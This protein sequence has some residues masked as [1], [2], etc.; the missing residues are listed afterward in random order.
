MLDLLC[1]IRHETLRISVISRL[2]GY[3]NIYSD[4]SVADPPPLQESEGVLDPDEDIEEEVGLFEP[5]KDLCK[6][7]FLWYY[8][9]YL[10]AIEEAEKKH[11]VNERFQIM[12]F[13]GGGNTMDGKFDYPSLKNRIQLI[14]QILDRETSRWAEEGAFLVKCDNTVASHLHRQRKQ[15]EEQYKKNSNVTLDIDLVDSKNPFVWILTY[16]GRP[17]T[18]LDGGMFRIRMSISPRFPD[19]QPRVTF[20]TKMFHHRIGTDGVLC[21]FAKK[22]DELS[23]HI[24]AIIE[25]LEEEHPPYDP[26]TVVNLEATKLFWGSEADK[27]QYNK[28]LR[29][30]VLRS[31]E[32]E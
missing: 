21:Y 22:H 4:G 1:Q 31:M 6:R 20:E 10:C 15:L 9:S 16:I 24:D 7:R 13:E 8:P 18:Q 27:K 23:S 28:Q 19:E 2:E 30:S 12:P 5:F 11:K 26:R 14:R 32:M 3:L 29:R 17:M 25:A